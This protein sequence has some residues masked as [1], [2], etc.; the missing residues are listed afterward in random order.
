MMT[1]EGSSP[2]KTT[3]FWAVLFA[4]TAFAQIPNRISYQ[5]LLT[6]SSGTPVADG[7]YDLRFEIFNARG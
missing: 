7:S 1:Y 4:I 6:T 5:G 2:M 3:L